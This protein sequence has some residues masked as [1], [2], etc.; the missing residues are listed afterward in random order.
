MSLRSFF[1]RRPLKRYEILNYFIRTRDCRDYLEIGISSGRCISRVRCAHKTGVDPNPR[2]QPKG[3][4][5]HPKTSD[6]FFAANQ[7]EFDLVFIDGLHWAEQALRDLLHSLAVLRSG[8]M[9][10][11]HDCHPVGEAE[12]RRDVNLESGGWKGDVWK[13]IAFTRRFL[14]GLFC[15]VIDLDQ[16]MGVVVPRAGHSLPA[17]TPEL[18][19]QAQ[20][21]FDSLGWCDLE[22][23]RG[24]LL[25][26][27]GDVSS[28][29][30]ELRRAR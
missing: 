8:G 15:C 22:R 19:A 5:L 1:R 11:L 2:A 27:V 29:E 17:L 9:V 6:D 12:Q 3:W 13:T 10:L 20:R 7:D 16:G 30:A 21:C 4:T 24:E 25:G 18:E 23:Q 14:P 28:L 26:L